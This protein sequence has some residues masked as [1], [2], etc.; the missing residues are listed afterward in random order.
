MSDLVMMDGHTCWRFSVPASARNIDE[1]TT[2]GMGYASWQNE[3]ARTFD[4]SIKESHNME[5]PK[6]LQ[7]RSHSSALWAAPWLMLKVC[8]FQNIQ[9]T[10]AHFKISIGIL[11]LKWDKVYLLEHCKKLYFWMVFVQVSFF[12][13]HSFNQN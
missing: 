12:H 9:K 6:Q 8:H 4:E 2:V 13:I 3:A 10:S 5:V 1:L 11:Q 7:Q